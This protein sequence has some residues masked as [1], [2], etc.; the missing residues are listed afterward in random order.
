V[1]D[2]TECFAELAARPEA[3]VPLDEAA[4]LIA[5]HARPD[6][7]LAA[8]LGRLDDLAA[9]VGE[10]TLDGLV[11]HLFRDLGFAGNVRDYYDPRNSYLDRVVDRR[12]G[13]PITLSVLAITVGRRL[14][15]PLSGVSMPGHFLVRDRVD[16]TVFVDPFHRGARL[17][18]DGCERVFHGIQG[19]GVPF[20]PAFLDPVGHRTILVRVLA[21]LRAVFAAAGDR[22][23][24]V[25]ALRLRTLVPGAGP[26]D[27]ADLATA[28]AA[29]GDYAGAARELDAVAAVVGGPLGEQ[30]ARAAVALRARLN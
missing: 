3:E 17:D 6:L 22:D 1:I 16:P 4:L 27:R 21:N 25:W 18:A 28:L 11:R 20:D 30:H 12:L 8:E 10:P 13:I 14:G 19:D 7:D 23:A 5:A 9:G 15:V 2:V 24:V 26:D 29:T